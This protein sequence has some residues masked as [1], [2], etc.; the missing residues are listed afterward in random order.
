MSEI[1][2]SLA[3]VIGIDRYFNNIPP[4]QTAANDAQ[5]LA[6]LIEEKYQYQVLLLLDTDATLSNI[7]EILAGFA[8]K[9][10][11]FPDGNK[12]QVA[13]DDRILFYFAGHGIAL[14]GLDNA[15][16]PAGFLIPQD[17]ERDDS[18]TWL[19]MQQLHDSLIQLPCRHS[20][21]ILDCCFAGTFRWAAVHREAVRSQKV[22]RE[23][24]A[25]YTSGCA[26]QVIT[27]AAHDEKAA[28]SLYRFGQRSESSNHSPFAELL[29][30][31]LEGEADLTKDG[32]ITATELY[33]Y[34]QSEF[35]KIA[36]KQTPGFAQLKHH[37]KG[38]YIFILPGFD[39]NQLP[40][41]PKLNEN[42]NPYKGLQSFE[43]ADSDKFFGRQG[44]TKNLVQFVT[45]HPLTVVLGASGS[46][47]SSLVKAGLLPQLKKTQPNWR[48]LSPIRPGE[49]PFSAL[50]SA[51]GNE[52]FPESLISNELVSDK[53]LQEASTSSVGLEK[54]QS[55]QSLLYKLS[56]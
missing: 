33:A 2:R 12:V 38:E 48:I 22:Y 53:D 50:N 35:G 54:G 27:S 32:V 23:R 37:D 26:Q 49:S 42:T 7:S 51:L 8:E 31:A 10:L 47:K 36:A 30:K 14:D 28:D 16:G 52:N 13:A 25:R 44:L 43:E 56:A 18:D 34:L 9:I 6:N 3:V 20:L 1:K 39:V 15:E 41:A 29:L 55:L 5:Q 17:G 11:V 24:Y 45:Q 21:I 46:G 19:S 4:L 40:P